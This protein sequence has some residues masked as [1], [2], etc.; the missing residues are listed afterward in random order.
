[1]WFRDLEAGTDRLDLDGPFADEQIAETFLSSSPDGRWVLDQV[2][3][4][5]GGEWQLFVRSQDADGT[6]RQGLRLPLRQGVTVSDAEEIVPAGDRAID[7]VAVTS[8]VVWVVDL[9]GGPQQV[10]RLGC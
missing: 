2:Q 10:R 6:W 9:D 7:D 4:G 8:G 5:D 1:V 3:K